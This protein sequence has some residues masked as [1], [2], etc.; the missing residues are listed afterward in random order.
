MPLADTKIYTSAVILEEVR[1][2]PC[3]T[4]LPQGQRS[5]PC[6]H[7]KWFS[8]IH[9]PVSPSPAPIQSFSFPFSILCFPEDKASS[10]LPDV[11][12]S[13]YPPVHVPLPKNFFKSQFFRNIHKSHFGQTGISTETHFSRYINFA[14]PLQEEPCISC[15]SAPSGSM[16]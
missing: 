12:S 8:G 7:P 2:S 15:R 1:K 4:L 11:C 3:S 9:Y 16:V 13:M 6:I 10:S 14:F 5:T